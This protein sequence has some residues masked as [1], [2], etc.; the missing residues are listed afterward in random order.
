VK[1]RFIAA[2]L[3][4]A[5]VMWLIACGASQRPSAAPVARHGDLNV[6]SSGGFTAAYR[7]LLPEF[8]RSAGAHVTTSYGPSMGTAPDAIPVRIARGEPVDVVIMVGAQLDKLIGEGKVV[9][10]SRVDLGKSMVGMAVRAGAPK[11]DISTVDSFKKALLDAKSIAYSDSA[12]GAYVSNVLFKR[13]GIADELAPKSREIPSEPV[14]NVVARG[15]A[16]I[17]FQQVSELLPVNGI[18]FVGPIPAELQKITVFS[19]GIATS[20]KEPE[21][22]RTLLRFLSSP[23]ARA[24]IINSGLEPVSP[25]PNR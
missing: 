23:D 13:L 8:E 10:T 3:L 6:M 21:L 15:E 25:T 22:G 2:T 5:V 18:T 20:S 14:G 17:G 4:V 19:A 1:P 12:S 16:E 11:P 9:A 7:Q 24:A